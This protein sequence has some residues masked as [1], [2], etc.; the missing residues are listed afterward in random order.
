M[1]NINE[2]NWWHR[3]KLPDG[4]YTPGRVFYGEDGGDWPTSRFGM[5]DDLTGKTVLDIGAFD[6]FFSFEAEKR[7]ARVVLATDI[8]QNGSKDG[9]DFAH[10]VLNSKVQFA[11]IG[12]YDMVPAILFDV[13]L[14]YGVLYHL[15][16]PTDALR[17]LYD[18]V[19]LEGVVLIETA[20]A[21]NIESNGSLLPTWEFRPG[22]D[23][24][25]TNK[26]YPSIKGLME[27]LKWVGFAEVSIVWASDLRA[28][29]KAIK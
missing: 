1:K 11:G 15:D 24:D 17:K 16:K 25:E 21:H 12:I 3:I 14:F 8:Y 23:G 20:I 18:L 28:T 4:S 26:W 7:G 9:F 6:G 13:V 27:Y 2:I 22:F 19:K 5:P 10:R 29:I